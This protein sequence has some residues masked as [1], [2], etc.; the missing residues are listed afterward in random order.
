MLFTGTALPGGLE[1]PEDLDTAGV[2][3]VQDSKS[4]AHTNRLVTRLITVT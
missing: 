1:D 2:E 4:H 3:G